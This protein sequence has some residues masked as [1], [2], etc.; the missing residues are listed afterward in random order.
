[1][2]MYD[3]TVIY[4]YATIEVL[5]FAWQVSDCKRGTK[6]A[7]WY[8]ESM[9]AYEFQLLLDFINKTLEL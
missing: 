7:T 3:E 1:M 2:T 9:L 5:R 8:P 4:I 6:Y